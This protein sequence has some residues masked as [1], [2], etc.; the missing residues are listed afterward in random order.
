[1]FITSC[2]D[3]R[4][5]Q[6]KEYEQNFMGTKLDLKLDVKKVEDYTPI[7]AK[8]S[9]HYWDSIFKNKYTSKTCSNIDSFIKFT[10]EHIT[11]QKANPNYSF[12]TPIDD[13]FIYLKELNMIKNGYIIYSN[14]SNRVLNNRFIATYSVNNPFLNNTRQTITKIYTISSNGDILNS[15]NYNEK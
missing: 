2:N 6:I 9:L 4:E 7:Y 11:L 5:N 8:D 3:K 13:F 14:D 12:T 10:N 15:V 1:M